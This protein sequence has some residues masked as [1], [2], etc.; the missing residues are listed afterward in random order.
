M[1]YSEI[2]FNYLDRG[3]IG[4]FVQNKITEAESEE[5]IKQKKSWK[6]SKLNIKYEWRISINLSKECLQN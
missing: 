1:L 3:I 4:T 6:N 5:E 2:C